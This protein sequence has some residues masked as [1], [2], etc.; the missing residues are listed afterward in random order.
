MSNTRHAK[1]GGPL[2]Q[3]RFASSYEQGLLAN[4]VAK[5]CSLL[6]DPEARALIWFYQ[7]LS[8]Q[9][10]GI[11]WAESEYHALTPPPQTRN[12]ED[13]WFWAGD[14]RRSFEDFCLNPDTTAFGRGAVKLVAIRDRWLRS[15]P[16]IVETSVSRA[17]ESALDY[18]RNVGC[19]VLIDGPARIGKT[20][21]ARDWCERSAGLARYAPA[22]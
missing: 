18:A 21:A 13:A 12:P 3:E 7:W 11:E 4:L 6:A 5:R 14:L 9:P 15:Q 16:G 19:L 8:W 10:G 17:V 22:R 20:F 2:R 1:P